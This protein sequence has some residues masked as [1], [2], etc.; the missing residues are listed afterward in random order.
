MDTPGK[1]KQTS[2][3]ERE[4]GKER[5]KAEKEKMVIHFSE[6]AQGD[7]FLEM[8]LKIFLKCVWQG[9]LNWTSLQ[10]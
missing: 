7:K 10:Q 6:L 5:E 4:K 1:R 9:V 2:S 3:S 8:K